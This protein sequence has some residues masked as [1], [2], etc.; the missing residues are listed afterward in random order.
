MLDFDSRFPQ[1]YPMFTRDIL[2]YG[3]FQAKIWLAHMLMLD[4]RS[5]LHHM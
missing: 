4:M 1:N 2:L 5:K 3:D